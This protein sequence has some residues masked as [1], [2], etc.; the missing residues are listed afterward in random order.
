MRTLNA[1][2]L[3]EVKKPLN[4]KPLNETKRTVT[5]TSL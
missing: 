3:N 2:T 4:G 5:E 1:K